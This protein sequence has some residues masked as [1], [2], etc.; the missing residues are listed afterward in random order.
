MTTR[1]NKNMWKVTT[2]QTN[3]AAHTTLLTALTPPT[4][5]YSLHAPLILSIH[6]CSTHITV[7]WCVCAALILLSADHELLPFLDRRMVSPLWNVCLKCLSLVHKL[8]LEADERF[9]TELQSAPSLLSVPQQFDTTADP[10]ATSH[11]RF[12]QSYAAYL[13]SKVRS[14]QLLHVSCERQQPADSKRWVMKLAVPTLVRGLPLLQRQFDALLLVQPANSSDLNHPIPIACMTLVI[15]DA[16]RLYS[17]LTVMM[18]AVL[19]RYE[20][21]TLPQTERMLQATHKFLIQN[22]KFRK[23]ADKL[24]KNGFVDRKLLPKF[25][26]V[27]Q[28]INKHNQPTNK[29]CN[30]TNGKQSRRAHFSNILT[31]QCVMCVMWSTS[32]DTCNVPPVARGARRRTRGKR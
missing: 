5:R 29:Q 23:W 11:S 1:P 9:L 7:C 18:L 31:C 25:D 27:S 10:T 8:S 15:K 17:V 6:H 19:E 21:M 14:F 2:L 32:A 20:S 30:A 13:V 16:F 12:I 4:T 22:A 24:C 28:P 3:T 26:A